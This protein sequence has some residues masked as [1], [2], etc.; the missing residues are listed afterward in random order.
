[1]KDQVVPRVIARMLIPFVL[2]FGFYVVFHGEIGPGGGFQGGVILASAVILHA[3]VHGFEETSRA[4]PQRWVDRIMVLGV[5]IY[6]GTGA[7]GLFRGSAF[8]DYR[9]LGGEPH[10]AEALG[11]T[12]VEFG[13]ALTVASVVITLFSK[14]ATSR[15]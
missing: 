6:V 10:A 11:M 2:V 8:L 1:M 12:L 5:L 9:A 13:V 15:G 14:F 3:L 4:I 7:V